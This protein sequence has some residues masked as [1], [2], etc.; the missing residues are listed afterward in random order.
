MLQL[1]IAES[2]HQDVNINLVES[3]EDAFQS[4][5]SL[6]SQ[7]VIKDKMVYTFEHDEVASARAKG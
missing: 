2:F 3:D 5:R 6:L 1:L 7:D 4:N